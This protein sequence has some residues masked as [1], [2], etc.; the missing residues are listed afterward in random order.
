MIKKDQIENI[1]NNFLQSNIK[2]QIEGKI[3]RKGKLQLFNIKQFYLSF[4]I[5]DQ[6]GTVRTYLIPYPF[7]IHY[8][9]D[10]ILFD[11][12]LKSL[13]NDCNEILLNLKM[14]NTSSA[15]R[16]FDKQLIL[17]KE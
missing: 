4:K 14:L 16:L 10:Q 12:T 6:K 1:V 5:I 9:N 17:K 8:E 13:S 15:S 11:Y 7:N 3:I 2:F